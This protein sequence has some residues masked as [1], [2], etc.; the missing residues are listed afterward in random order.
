M[1]AEDEFLLA[2]NLQGLV[3]ALGHQVVGL[4]DTGTQA[5]AMA[6]AMQPDLVLMDIKIPEIDGIAAAREIAH[7]H[8]IPTIIIT[9][10]SDTAFV[11]E[12]A[13]AGVMMYLLKPVSLGELQAAI[14]VTMAR[15]GEL[16][17]LR[18][19]VGDLKQALH[20]RKVIE[21][22]KGILMDSMRLSE[23]DA[24]RR[25]Q[26]MSQQG[27]R[28]MVDIAQAVITTQTLWEEQHQRP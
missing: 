11:E 2:K 26:T 5:L 15:F 13:D 1:I 7:R 4:A 21:R 6:G 3:D 17:A 22:A 24:F 14:R 9:A 20:Q 19:E 27:N 28:P 25:L 23:N 12:A 10:F 18:K 16:Q 8:N